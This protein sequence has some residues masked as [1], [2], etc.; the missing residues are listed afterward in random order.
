M[1]ISVTNSNTNAPSTAMPAI[2]RARPV[3]DSP[4]PSEGD[5]LLL[6]VGAMLGLSVSRLATWAEPGTAYA[7]AREVAPL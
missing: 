2:T 7:V 5:V 3:L 6:T 4:D 1:H